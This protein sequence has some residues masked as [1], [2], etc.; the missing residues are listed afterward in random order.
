LFGISL[1]RTIKN[2]K[3]SDLGMVSWIEQHN[4]KTL[5]KSIKNFINLYY[6]PLIKF[7]VIFYAVIAFINAIG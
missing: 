7:G 2:S 3:T 1:S 5:A 6:M 4:K